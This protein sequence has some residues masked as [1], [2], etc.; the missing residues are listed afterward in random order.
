MPDIEAR[1]RMNIDPQSPDFA[2]RIAEE[3][4]RRREATGIGDNYIGKN[5]LINLPSRTLIAEAKDK[6]A[7]FDRRRLFARL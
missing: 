6:R 3:Y 4:R 7:E 5:V 1:N 2:K